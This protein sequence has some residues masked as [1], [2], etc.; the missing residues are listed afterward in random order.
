MGQIKDSGGEGTERDEE[1]TRFGE[2]EEVDKEI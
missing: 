1:E 2:E